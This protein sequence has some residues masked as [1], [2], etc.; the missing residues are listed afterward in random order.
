MART[1]SCREPRSR[2]AAGRTLVG[3][4]LVVAMVGPACLPPSLAAH[5]I[6][7]PR[8]RAVEETPDPPHVEVAFSADGVELRGWLFPARGP[9]KWY[10]RLPG[11]AKPEPGRGHCRRETPR[12]ARLRSPRQ[13]Q[14][15]A[16]PVRGEVLDLRLL[17]EARR[18]SRD[19][20]LGAERVVLGGRVAGAA[21]AIEA[22]AEDPRVAGVVAVSSFSSMEEIRSRADPPLRRRRPGP[23][24]AAGGRAPGLDA[25]EGRRFGR[26]GAPRPRPGAAPAWRPRRVH[27]DRPHAADYLGAPGSRELVQ[28]PGAHHANV[29]AFDAAW[30]AILAWLPSVPEDGVHWAVQIEGHDPDVQVEA[31]PGSDLDR[32]REAH[33]PCARMPS[34]RNA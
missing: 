3:A 33:P 25:R 28:V 29:L 27:A 26:G 2:V 5:M 1:S 11:R 23:G 14:P 34:T 10:R 15:R 21:V 32:V 9:V 4:F 19:H 24:R 16:W 31:R 8:R 18:K 17:R 22:A 30:A 12:P 6:L 20:F 13:R 7:E